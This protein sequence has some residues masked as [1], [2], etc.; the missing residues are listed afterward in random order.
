VEPSGPTTLG[1]RLGLSGD[2]LYNSDDATATLEFR[3]PG[4]AWRTALP[5]HRV[6][7]EHAPIG[8]AVSEF[9]GSIFDLEPATVYE[10]RLV[11]DGGT[12]ATAEASTAPL[13][14]DPPALRQVDVATVTELEAALA[15]AQPGDH[16][17]LRDGAYVGGWWDLEASG[18]A[19]APIVIEGDSTDG[20]VLDGAGC[21]LCA[22]LDVEGSHVR[23]RSLT[24]RNALHGLRFRGE[25]ASGNVAS[26][27]KIEA[28][29]TGIAGDDGQSAS[30][31]CDNVLLGPLAWPTAGFDDEAEL[32]G[33][34]QAIGVQGEGHVVCHNT[35]IGWGTGIRVGV[36]A[37]SVD[38]F[39]NDLAS[40]LVEG[41]ALGGVS[42]N[43][44]VVRNRLTNV[45][46]AV[47]M[48]SVDGGPVYSVRNLVVNAVD[49]QLAL[50]GGAS[51]V[52]ALHGTYLSAGEALRSVELTAAHDFLVAGNLFVGAA[53]GDTVV[54]DGVVDRGWF[55]G[56][57]W[58][59]DGRFTWSQLGAW[60]SFAD[61][62]AAGGFESRGVLLDGLPLDSGMPEDFLGGAWDP[63]DPVDRVGPTLRADSLA[64][65]GAVP[66]PNI[67]DAS[68]GTGPDLGAH[69]LGCPDPV[70]G[71]RAT[72]VVAAPCAA[73]AEPGAEDV[74]SDGDG[75]TDREE[76]SLGSD[77]S[78]S[79]SDGDTVPD[80]DERRTDTD[81]DGSIDLIDP[82]D[83]GDGW[84]TE[85][86]GVLDPDCDGVP[87]YL[88]L[89]SDG[90]GVA[91][92]AEPAWALLDPGGASG[93]GP[94]QP[95][96]GCGCSTKNPGFG[97]GPAGWGW[98]FGAGALAARAR[99]G[100][101]RRPSRWRR[102]AR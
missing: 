25:G 70:Y 80:G 51:G 37:R 47:A 50:R 72:E 40:I 83:D 77:P 44:R 11:V 64:V 48:A 96:L 59:P 28:V 24:L 29:T 19:E 23:V 27:L 65:D 73:G 60:S 41:V 42:G 82:D 16:I 85:V 66:I 93:G 78:S 4:E 101:G 95:A 86:E 46:T 81:G 3:E 14:A 88:D 97:W 99:T 8:G 5:P 45:R 6:R 94:A 1:L 55:D 84:P 39:G 13:L 91:D 31:I 71:P 53:T 62:A 34:V 36:G 9:A 10:V 87:N 74:D 56:N 12:E 43:V 15:D 20:T 54:W 69:E 7:P 68:V 98:L 35:V 2:D 18:T 38:V 58:W 76:A 49:D 61:L 102:T 90:D 30:T 17:Q 32:E 63:F 52:Y 92:A 57:G 75:L 33:L 100:R 79:D 89:D 21:A 67:T 26:R 22:V